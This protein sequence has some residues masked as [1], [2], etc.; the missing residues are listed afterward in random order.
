MR[1]VLFLGVANST[2]TQMAEAI[3]RHYGG[4]EFTVHSAGLRP[5]EVHPLT[6]R[7]LEEAGFNT[8]I[9]HAKGIR[10]FLGRAA[11]DCAIIVC[12]PHEGGPNCYPFAMRTLNWACPDPLAGEHD[13]ARQLEA[14]RAARDTLS[15]NVRQWLDDEIERQQNAP[16]GRERRLSAVGQA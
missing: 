8:D 1:M 9:L 16:A 4:D 12:E 5:T 6:R 2:R 11:V 3:L 10:R 13:E 15:R 7:V 14:F